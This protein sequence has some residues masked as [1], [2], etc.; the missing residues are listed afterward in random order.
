MSSGGRV[1]KVIELRDQIYIDTQTTRGEYC[2]IVIERNA[3]SAQVKRGDSVR[4]EGL[5]VY[6][7]VAGQLGGE[8]TVLERVPRNYGP[9]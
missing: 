1:V 7:T 4:W 8:A 5:K 3:I 9:K 6:W 2:D